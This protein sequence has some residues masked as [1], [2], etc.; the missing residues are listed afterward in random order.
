[1]AQIELQNDLEDNNFSEGVAEGSVD[2]LPTQG[3]DYSKY[4]TDHLKMMLRPGILHRNEA[5]F[6]ALIRKELQKR[7][8]QSQQGVAEASGD[9]VKSDDLYNV[10]IEYFNGGKG[11]KNAMVLRSKAVNGMPVE[12]LAELLNNFLMKK[13]GSKLNSSDAIDAVKNI[14]YP[15]VLEQDVSEASGDQVKKVF[16]KNGKPVGEVGI[17]P[18]ASPGVGQWY[19]KCYQYDIDNSG[20]DSY[21]EAVGELKY[22]MKQ[23]VSEGSEEKDPVWNKG[24]PMPKDYTCHCGIAVHPSVR[25][26]KAI[27]IPD[28]P[29][30]KKQDMAEGTE[31]STQV[32]SDI[33]ANED[34]DALYDLMSA[35][36]EAGKIVQRMY[37][38]VSGEEGLHPDDD[39]EE[40]LNRVFDHL[41]QDYG[42]QDVAEGLKE[43][44]YIVIA[45]MGENDYELE[46]RAKTP[47]GALMQA[48]KWQK[49]NHIREVHFTVKEK[50]VAEGKDPEKRA[51]LDDLVSMYRDSTDPSDYYDSEY[52]DPEEVLNMIRA[53]FGNRVASQIEAGTDKMHF[54]RKD[55]DQGYDP[56]SWRKPVDRQTKAGKM[57][58]QDSDY[59][60]NTIKA[61][62]R[63]SGKSATEGVVEGDVV[64][65]PKKHPYELLT[66]CPKCGGLLQGGKDEKGRLKMCIP[67]M[68]LYRAPIQQG[69]TEG[70]GRG[71]LW[72][73]DK[74]GNEIRK[75]TVL[76]NTRTGKTGP[77]TGMSSQAGKTHLTIKAHDDSYWDTHDN[78]EVV[79]KKQGVAKGLKE[80]DNRTPSGDR[81]EKRNNSPEEKAKQDKEQ[82]KRLTATSP[83]MRKKLR[84][85]E[86]KQGVAENKLPKP[87]KKWAS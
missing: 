74:H 5:R 13:W 70:N 46:F 56:M 6:K 33:V 17:D 71:L 81:R 84:L 49:Q 52:E 28:C 36:T 79:K 63:N 59:R 15:H 82:Q 22:C 29:Y 65:F 72:I 45:S 53:E 48:K 83:E 69:M 64:P 10:V 34:F 77:A 23:G 58:K 38:N 20:Y 1:M 19:M 85:P 50:G 30:A 12:D 31:D 21:E 2:Q 35:N 60:K 73:H 54:P 4:D 66:N 18:E 47:D 26:P 55:H 37:N 44:E 16:K 8:Q 43:K 57:Y 3:A 11:Y 76:K 80:M 86:P 67:C 87:Y 42:Q 40:I 41:P 27:H 7:E 61:R 14:V 68:T 32:L 62:Y 9:Q 25:N 24:T 39:F 78:Y 51:R 75:G